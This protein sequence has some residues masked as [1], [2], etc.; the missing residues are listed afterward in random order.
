M[1]VL[2]LHHIVAMNYSDRTMNY[3]GRWFLGLTGAT[4]FLSGPQVHVERVHLKVKQHCEFCQKKYSDVKNLLRHME[5][6][7]NTKEPA[8]QQSYQQLRWSPVVL[9]TSGLD[10]IKSIW[11]C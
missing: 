4:L 6:R 7:H 1:S 11:K 9:Y 2:E 10:S 5:Q 8:V 3:S